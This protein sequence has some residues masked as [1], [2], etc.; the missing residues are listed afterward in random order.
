MDGIVGVRL[1]IR[2]AGGDTSAGLSFSVSGLS[3][4]AVMGAGDAE[5][6]RRL[7]MSSS[8]C[9][10]IAYYIFCA[11]SRCCCIR[12]CIRSLIRCS[13]LRS[14]SSSSCGGGTDVALPLGGMLLGWF[15]L[16]YM[17]IENCSR[18]FVMLLRAA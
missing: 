10:I 17:Q 15:G 4:G 6:V 3:D 12:R 1:Y 14:S 8:I 11:S 5:G 16:R 18:R 2:E 13:I 7:V 9:F